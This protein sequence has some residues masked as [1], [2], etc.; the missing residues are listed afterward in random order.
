MIAFISYAHSLLQI[1]HDQ[2]IDIY[3]YISYYFT[4]NNFNQF[5]FSIR[6]VI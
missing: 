6:V 1:K 4:G 2:I 5:V 3:L